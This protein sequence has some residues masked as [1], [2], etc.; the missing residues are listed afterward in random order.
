VTLIQRQTELVAAIK[1][2]YRMRIETGYLG[3]SGA[4]T[5][6]R[7]KRLHAEQMIRDGYTKR[8]AWDSANDC[9]QMA[10]LQASYESVEA[11]LGCVPEPE[12]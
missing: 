2:I 3:G 10:W 8:E 4:G 9:D 12:L 1:P 11:G 5:R 6:A 7:L